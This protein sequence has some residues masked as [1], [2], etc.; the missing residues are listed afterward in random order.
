MNVSNL[1][2]DLEHCQQLHRQLR[3]LRGVWARVRCP[4]SGNSDQVWA[5]E[6]E[7]GLRVSSVLNDLRL[8]RQ[9]PSTCQVLVSSSLKWGYSF[10]HR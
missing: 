6:P 10:P 5:L 2:Q 4:A 7:V 9:A 8:L 3:K 1:G